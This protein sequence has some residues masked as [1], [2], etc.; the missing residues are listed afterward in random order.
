ISAVAL[1][2]PNSALEESVVN[3][4]SNEYVVR[5]I[6]NNAPNSLINDVSRGIIEATTYIRSQSNGGNNQ[7]RYQ[8]D[9]NIIHY[10][11][12]YTQ[13]NIFGDS[14]YVAEKTVSTNNINRVYDFK[15]TDVKD[16]DWKNIF[17]KSTTTSTNLHSGNAYYSGI[18]KWNIYTAK[19]FNELVQRDVS[20]I[21]P[22]K[23]KTIPVGP[24]K[25]LTAAYT[26]APKMGYKFSFDLKTT[27]A[28]SDKKI[29]ITPRFYYIS[30]DGSGYNKN[31]KLFYK[32]SSNKYVDISNYKIYFVP[33]DGYRLTLDQGT[34]NFSSSHISMKTLELGTTKKITLNQKMMEV[35]DNTFVQIWYGEYKLPNS[36]IAVE[37]NNGTYNINEQLKNGYIGVVFDIVVEQTDGSKI[38]YSQNNKLV[39]NKD[40]TS[41]WDYEGFLGFS[42]PG[43]KVTV[44]SPL[45]LRLEKA[46]WKIERDDLYN[47]IKGTVILYDTDLRAASD[48]E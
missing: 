24:Y 38:Y 28:N 48:Y 43:S 7:N 40:N 3:Q 9:K 45:R 17:R 29:I 16:I 2:D 27:G 41:Q 10:S 36:T 21:G 44:D 14:T 39:N 18:K 22:T 42:N 6:S 30:K 31:I 23:Q 34:Y 35:S 13:K 33:N 46:S 8:G 1:A 5:A 15:V 47:E 25:H 11:K 12:Y 26:K 20:E 32:N 4:G 19:N 37:L